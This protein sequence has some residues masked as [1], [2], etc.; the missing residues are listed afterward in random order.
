[1]NIAGL[2]SHH[3]RYRPHHQAVVCGDHRLNFREFE[4]RVVK[5]ANALSD[6][7]LGP[8]DK[9]AT[10]LGNCLELLEV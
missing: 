7:G 5:T 8:G 1:M 6:L 4:A 3:A 9:V 2:L 10:L